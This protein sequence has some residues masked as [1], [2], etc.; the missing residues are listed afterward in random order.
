MF[1]KKTPNSPGKKQKTVS[2]DTPV[3]MWARGPE[4][5][6]ARQ[7]HEREAA[8]QARQRAKEIRTVEEFRAFMMLGGHKGYFDLTHGRYRTSSGGGWGEAS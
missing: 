7:A 4:Q 1:W 3:E 6:Q 2:I 8:N 5:R